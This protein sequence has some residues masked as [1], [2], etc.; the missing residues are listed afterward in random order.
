MYHTSKIYVVVPDVAQL[1]VFDD[2]HDETVE[3]VLQVLM[4]EKYRL[5]QVN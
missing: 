3:V 1:V 2:S 5:A 4:L